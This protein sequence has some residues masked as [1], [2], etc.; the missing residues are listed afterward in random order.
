MFLLDASPS[1][2]ATTPHQ[3]PPK[4]ARDA[5]GNPRTDNRPQ[6]RPARSHHPSGNIADVNEDHSESEKGMKTAA[7]AAAAAA[8]VPAA[9]AAAAAASADADADAGGADVDLD[10]MAGESTEA[11]AMAG[12]LAKT[13]VGVAR[14]NEQGT[15]ADALNAKHERRGGD[16]QG[17]RTFSSLEVAAKFV[18]CIPAKPTASDAPGRSTEEAEGRGKKMKLQGK[19]VGWRT[20][21]RENEARER[22]RERERERWGFES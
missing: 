3:E 17:Q 11:G 22:E 8:A 19:M 2:T 9:A 5:Q 21:P 16:P 4:S 1:T 18:D 12:A 13:V 10:G 15:D 7:A 20:L 6:H 14:K